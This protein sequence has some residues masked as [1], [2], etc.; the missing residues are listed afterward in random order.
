MDRKCK[1]N[2]LKPI[3]CLIIS[4]IKEHFVQKEK[5]KE[6]EKERKRERALKTETKAHRNKQKQNQYLLREFHYQLLLMVVEM[7]QFSKWNHQVIVTNILFIKT[8]VCA[9]LK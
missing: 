5:G 3:R 7:Y 9:I 6:R 4:L 8:Q 1:K 2:M